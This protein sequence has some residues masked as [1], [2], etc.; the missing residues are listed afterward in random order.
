[1]PKPKTKGTGNKGKGVAGRPK[2]SENSETEEE[3]A[4]K[5]HREKMAEYRGQVLKFIKFT[6]NLIII[7]S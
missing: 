3:E 7:F 4:R 1:M 2:S 6:S 5:Y